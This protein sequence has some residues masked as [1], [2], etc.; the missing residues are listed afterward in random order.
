MANG[1]VAFL[2]VFY[3]SFVFRQAL[4]F[5]VVL[6]VAIGVYVWVEWREGGYLRGLAEKRYGPLD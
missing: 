6:S 4:W 2:I 3:M 1:V 5:G